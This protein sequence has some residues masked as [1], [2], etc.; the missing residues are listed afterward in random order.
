M[1]PFWIFAIVFG[2]VLYLFGV[3][4]ILGPILYNDWSEI[5]RSCKNAAFREYK[6][7]TIKS[8]KDEEQ[9]FIK[10]LDEA[11]IAA[12]RATFEQFKAS[13]K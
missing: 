13:K 6:T 12:D 5:P 4:I 2:V 10:W 7:R 11:A 3:C 9:E 8:L 1:D